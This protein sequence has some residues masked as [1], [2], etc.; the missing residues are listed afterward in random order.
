VRSGTLAAS[1]GAVAL[2]RNTRRLGWIVPAAIVALTLVVGTVH[3]TDETYVALQGDT[4]RYLMNGVFFFDLAHDASIVGRDIRQYAEQYYARYPALSL[5]FHPILPSLLVVPV[6]ELFG[7]SVSSARVVPL[8]SFMASALLLLWLVERIYDRQ[9]ALAAVVIFVSSP[10]AARYSRSFMSEMPAL[11]MVMAAVFFC[12]RYRECRRRLDL[13]LLVAFT[14][15]SLY[16]KQLAALMVPVYAVYLVWRGGGVKRFM[17]VKF[18]IGAIIAAAVVVP[19]IS[20]TLVLSGHNVRW[21]VQA[22]TSHAQFDYVTIL[23]RALVS[24]VTW[25]II[26]LAAIGLVRALWTR[27]ARSTLFILWVSAFVLLVVLVIKDV[28]ADRYTIYWVPAICTLAATGTIGWRSRPIASVAIVLLFVSVGWEA[29]LASSVN[30]AGAGGYEDAARYV[31]EHTH[32][33]A[34]V[35]FSGDLD[36]GY[37]VFFVRKHDLNRRLVVLRSDKILTTSYMGDVSYKEQIEP[38]QVDEVLGEFGTQFV[39]IEDRPS[40]SR[41]LEWLRNRVK[42][43][44][45]VERLRVQIRSSDGRLND[46]DLAVFENVGVGPPNPDAKMRL[47]LP[48]AKLVIDL[49]L[50]DVFAG[51]GRRE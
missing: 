21:I 39:V 37:F 45:Y 15:L 20:M 5:G 33:N 10:F 19:L 17:N 1:S 50:G 49:R 42:R 7:I 29:L 8:V 34:T 41:A 51:P 22:A 30:L 9:V 40:S 46:V 35:L 3:I 38:A 43:P 26:A 44:P 4:P 6:F 31:V 16:G 48:I 24:Q 47:D 13:G 36:T 2:P 32:G 18:A 28:G 11:A 12:E 27:D 23:V 25:P 14:V